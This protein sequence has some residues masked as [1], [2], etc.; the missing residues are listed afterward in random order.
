MIISF[1]VP[2]LSAAFAYAI[3][4][5]AQTVGPNLIGNPSFSASG[6]SPTGWSKGGYGVNIRV[7]TFP[8][9]G[10]DDVYAAQVSITNYTSGDAKWY[11]NDVPI[12]GGQT[13]QFSDYFQSDVPSIIT[14]RYAL[15]GGG[16]LYKDIASF[17]ANSSYENA[18]ITFIA[19]Q[20]A[21]SLTV[22]H[23]IKQA[24]TLITDNYSLN[25]VIDE[26]PPGGSDL[27][28]NSDFEISGS[29][30]KPANWNTGSWGS[31]TASF[32]Y[33]AAGVSGS[34]A[35]RVSLANY[36]SGDAKWYFT[37]FAVSPGVYTYSDQYS[38]N[39]AS[40]ITIRYQYADG[41]FSYSDAGTFPPSSG[42]TEASV[43]LSVPVNVANI[44][45]FHL[46]A[47]NGMLTIDDTSLA[48][49]SAFTGIF[50]TGAVSLT[51]D[52]ATLVQYQNAVPKM[53]SAG[54]KG[55]F[56]IVT[57]RLADYGY[58]GYMSIAQIDA[59]YGA[60][61]EIAA[62][63]RTHPR[64]PGLT[65]A[66]QQSEIEGSW[67]DLRAMNV[68][69]VVSFAYPF[70]EYNNAVTGGVESAGFTN[71]RG[72]NNSYAKSTSD[73]LAL[74]S[75]GVDVNTTV[76]DVKGWIDTAIA[77]KEWLILRFHRIDTSGVQY[78][79]TPNTFNQIIDYLVQSNVP[80]VTMTE[81]IRDL[82]Q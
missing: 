67:Q 34:R 13:Y 30:N 20:D 69:P 39:V 74:P 35:A 70:G 46:I 49:T 21:V 28:P 68:G 9:P 10:Q 18:Q 78:S 76:A 15:S 8:V 22:F 24:G 32:T 16:Y 36:V 82:L 41:S 40:K 47:S 63:T 75:R 59:L 48:F 57:R 56:F 66:Q 33:P 25:K 4:V 7:L 52:D 5:Q 6:T 43:L 53:N 12:E 71:A 29:S 55:T 23:L 3:P 44:T 61:H 42:F 31:N 38:S 1:A 72:T 14:I 54:L 45:I 81:G 26:P 80:V 2:A 11:F 27:I 77:N 37:P 73:R 50:T 64:L 19:P 65:P 60:G 17:A 51:L 58:P 62:H 79:T